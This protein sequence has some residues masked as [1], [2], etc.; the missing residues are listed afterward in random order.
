MPAEQISVVDTN[1]A[2]IELLRGLIRAGDYVLVKGSR[3]AMM[4]GI[5]AALQRQPGQ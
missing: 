3:G 1:N 2:A 5:V 4:E